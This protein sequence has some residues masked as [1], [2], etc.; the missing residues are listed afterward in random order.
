MLPSQLRSIKKLK[1]PFPNETSQK[2]HSE[3]WTKL[4]KIVWHNSKNTRPLLDFSLFLRNALFFPLLFPLCSF[5]FCCKTLSMS[6]IQWWWYDVGIVWF[7]KKIT[8][9][10]CI[11]LPWKALISRLWYIITK[12]F[13]ITCSEVFAPKSKVYAMDYGYGAVVCFKMH[14]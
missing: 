11:I 3:K 8:P 6:L 9:G 14:N 1:K 4:L 5:K 10:I 12:N 7:E 2:V 13:W